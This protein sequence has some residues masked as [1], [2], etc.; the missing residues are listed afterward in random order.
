[1]P[2]QKTTKFH[3]GLRVFHRSVPFR[4]RGHP[5]PKINALT[6]GYGPGTVTAVTSNGVAVQYD[7]G[8]R[9]LYDDGWF[10]A[11]A[12]GPTASLEILGNG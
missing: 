10:R 7:S 9:G 6:D 2:D 3:P 5:R 12:D 11:V 8:A 1:M 4:R